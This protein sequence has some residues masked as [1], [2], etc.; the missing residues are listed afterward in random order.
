MKFIYLLGALALTTLV[1]CNTQPE[2][3]TQTEVVEQEKET[4]TVR[5]V[6]V[7]KPAKVVKVQAP[8]T[9]EVEKEKGTSI[10]INKDGGSFKSDKID[11][12]LGN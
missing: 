6:E 5:V 12:D 9:V 8:T 3:T 1:A 2:T 4:E 7:E 11:I 10:K